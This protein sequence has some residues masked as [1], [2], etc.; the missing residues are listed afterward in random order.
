MLAQLSVQNFAIVNFLELDLQSGMTTVTGETGAG[1]S[2]AIDALGLCLGERA[3]AGMIRQ[4][5]NRAEI[6]AQFEIANNPKAAAW[7][8][9]NDLDNDGQCILRRVISDNG[10][11]KAY[12]N[13]S[14][15][16]VSHL[17]SLGQL[18]V[19]IHGQNAHQRL[20]K[21]SYQL[22]ILDQY[23]Q[24][25][26]QLELVAATYQ[27]WKTLSNELN[28][29]QLDFSQLQAQQQLLNYQVE[30]L[31]EFAPGLNE[32]P[33]LEQQH[34]QLAN[35]TELQEK[36]QQLLHLLCEDEQTAITDLLRQAFRL[37]EQ[38]QQ[39]DPQIEEVLNLLQ[40]SQIQ[41][42]EASQNLN[43]YQQGLDF[44]PESFQRLDLRISNW[45]DLARKHQVTPE[46][47]GELHLQL[48]EQQ[49]GFSA[50]GERITELDVLIV[51][52]WEDYQQQS[53]KLSRAR[54]RAA[55]NLQS[56]LQAEIRKL[57]MPHA[58]CQLQLSQFD[59]SAP[60]P[61][62]MDKLE[63][64]ISTNPGMPLQSMEKVASGGELSRIGLALQVICS[65]NIVTPTL[66]FDEVDVGI[67][68]PTAAVV[69]NMLRQLG[70]H[71][72]VLCVT[73]LPQV[74]GHGH[75][76]ML[77]SK[78]Q[79]KKST[80]TMMTQLS[81]EQR[82]QELARLLAGDSVTDKAIENAK[83]LLHSCSQP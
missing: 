1:K 53:A 68:G 42:E 80:Q 59:P 61:N 56:Q 20:L 60:N 67:S 62:G 35:S 24:H 4:G 66:I 28:Q 51:K 63:L 5:A 65:A 45:L 36:S 25:Q 27:N 79:D 64:L 15:V 74:A 22:Q 3:D 48:L 29:A 37:G 7:L 50:Q 40:E 57:S 13:A 83:E 73:H 31:N 43:H 46:Q 11:S 55:K 18:L 19:N 52:A 14:P 21:P 82:I 78:S 8:Q 81:S 75:Q 72:Q 17:R 54:G 9:E 32:Y 34:Q 6:S 38:I 33:E 47:L 69:G 76:Q 2:I 16:P 39:I 58:K 49:Q 41:L 10:R 30:E 44:D 70:E 12:I 26:S 71:T 77:V 23:G